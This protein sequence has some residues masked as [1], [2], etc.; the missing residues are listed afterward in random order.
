[1]PVKGYFFDTIIRQPQVDEENLDPE[2]NLEEFKIISDE[3]CH[4]L[5]SEL[6]RVRNSSRCILGTFGGT[7]FDNLSISVF[8]Y[9]SI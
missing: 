3:D 4:Y 6:N 9:L 7:A 2:E 1:M 5:R 8:Q